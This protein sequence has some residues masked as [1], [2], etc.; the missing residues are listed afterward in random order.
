MLRHARTHTPSSC[1]PKQVPNRQDFRTLRQ[2]FLSLF[3]RET[4][5]L[6][7]SNRLVGVSYAGLGVS[8]KNLPLVSEE[9]TANQ[10]TQKS[11]LLLKKQI[12]T[13]SIHNMIQKKTKQ[14]EDVR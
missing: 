6:A 4:E 3:P 12:R 2:V 8:I 11:V 7:N 10:S 14:R 13:I 5:K 1:M 9:E